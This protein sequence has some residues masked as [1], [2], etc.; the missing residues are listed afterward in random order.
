M[1]PE[2]FDHYLNFTPKA[3]ITRYEMP[4]YVGARSFLLSSKLSHDLDE[5]AAGGA[6]AAVAVAPP[7]DHGSLPAAAVRKEAKTLQTVREALYNTYIII[8][9]TSGPRKTTQAGY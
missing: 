1:N 6:D 4:T 7:L 2:L 5:A 9:I 3:A 8:T